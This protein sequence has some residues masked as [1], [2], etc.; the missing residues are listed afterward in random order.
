MCPTEAIVNALMSAPMPFAVRRFP[1]PIAPIFR[2]VS[3]KIGRRTEY[4]H[5]KI[6][7]TATSD[8]SAVS[9]TS[10]LIYARLISI[11]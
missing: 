3:A 9:A 10:D 4:D 6:V 8:I 11:D 2:I 7:S 5:P 1:S